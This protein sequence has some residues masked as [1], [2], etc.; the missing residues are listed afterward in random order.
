MA[1]ITSSYHQSV[2]LSMALEDVAISVS[3]LPLVPA[4]L[5][6]IVDGLIS[7]DENLERNPLLHW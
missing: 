7:K 2:T 4:H 1:W 6:L 5:Q 3:I